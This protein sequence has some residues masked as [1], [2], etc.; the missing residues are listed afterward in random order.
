M[1]KGKGAPT[2]TKNKEGAAAAPSRDSKRRDED[3]SLLFSETSG[4]LSL[5]QGGGGNRRPGPWSSTKKEKR[6][7]SFSALV[8]EFVP[9]GVD[10]DRT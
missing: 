5:A 10:R 2:P 1:S 9:S 8:E 4:F 7:S 3:R 6:I